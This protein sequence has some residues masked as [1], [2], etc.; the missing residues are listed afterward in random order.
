M[1]CQVILLSILLG[2]LPEGIFFAW[3][4]I[5]AKRMKK[6][7]AIHFAVFSIAMFVIVGTILSYSIWFY[8]FIIVALYISLKVL[9]KSTEFLDLFLLT[10]PFLL[11]GIAGYPCYYLA[12]ILPSWLPP[13][14][15]TLIINR[16]VII[17]ILSAL[18]PHLN[19]WY[20][21]YKRLW[22]RHKDNKIK[23]ITI[24]NISILLCNVLIMAAYLMLFI[25]K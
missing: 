25:R 7:E 9:C 17:I 23:S 16:L 4:V 3:F 20:N 21:A 14:L 1:T 5:G 19:K 24:R 18:Y 6:N 15:T 13:N 11:F 8:L 12:E 2:L 22:N 10:I